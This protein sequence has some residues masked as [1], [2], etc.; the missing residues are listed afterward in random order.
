MSGQQQSWLP[1]FPILPTL[2]F[3]L[4]K[5]KISRKRLQIGLTPPLPLNEVYY[6]RGFNPFKSP[7]WGEGLGLREGSII[8]M[9]LLQED[10]GSAERAD[11][12]GPGSGKQPFSLMI[13]NK[14]K[15]AERIGDR[16]SAPAPVE[17]LLP[18]GMLTSVSLL[19][20]MGMAS[21]EL[22]LHGSRQIISCSF[23]PSPGSLPITPPEDKA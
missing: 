13:S 10:L 9:N 8:P 1:S 12:S 15:R 14:D 18:S 23:L 2:A 19:C 4:G 6:R 22:Q 16:R 7:M 20:T 3:H 17:G 5:V 21:T 11:G